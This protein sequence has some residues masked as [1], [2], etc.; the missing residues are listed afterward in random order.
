MGRRR[1][2]I[3]KTDIKR[4]V[5]AI[6]RSRNNTQNYDEYNDDY[7]DYDADEY[8]EPT[9]ILINV[10]YHPETRRTNLTFREEKPYKTIVR[11]VT[12]NYQRYPVYSDWKIKSKTI[13][14]S[15][16][17]DNQTLEDLPYN[18]N[19][20]VSKHAFDIVS[21]IDDIEYP[22]WFVVEYHERLMKIEKQELEAKIAGW[23]YDLDRRKE[24]VDAEILALEIEIDK[25][26]K[27]NKEVC[28]RCNRLKKKIDRIHNPSAL[29]IIF[30]V[31]TLGFYQLFRTSSHI[32]SLEKKIQKLENLSQTHKDAIEDLKNTIIKKK[33]EIEIKKTS[34]R[35]KVKKID[36]EI[37]ALEA[38]TN[39]AIKGV[40]PLTVDFEDDNEFMPLKRFI[41][42]PYEKIVGC[43]II[44]NTQNNRCYV[45]QSKDVCKR[46]KQHFH[47][48]EPANIIFA[49]DYYSTEPQSRADLFEI[50]VIKCETKNDLDTTERNLIDIYNAFS[51]GYNGTNG[52]K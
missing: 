50:K 4:L 8:R 49:E 30:L 21:K 17:L 10:E 33:N 1:Q 2:L 14:A 39:E 52:N 5:S 11:Y 3:T 13:K 9:T 27:L 43:Y 7:D 28:S 51:E 41:G 29:S 44:K 19:E 47:G 12:E 32:A 35:D 23:E 34:T 22:S 20:Y 37:A 48:L 31:C 42:I 46:I 24:V 36:E 15:I 26:Q 45:G 6:S 38:R 16:K 40:V 25:K 18:E